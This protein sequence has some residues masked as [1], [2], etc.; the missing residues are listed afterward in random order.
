MKAA[1]MF[2]IMRNANPNTG[3]NTNLFDSWLAV[4]N[5]ANWEK[6]TS[7]QDPTLLPGY[8]YFPSDWFIPRDYMIQYARWIAS[9]PAPQITIADNQKKDNS[10]ILYA[11]VAAA[12]LFFFM[13]KK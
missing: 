2:A 1:G 9:A 8:T 13:K 7:Q 6:T 4:N 11:G 10:Y 5:I 3:W 12:V